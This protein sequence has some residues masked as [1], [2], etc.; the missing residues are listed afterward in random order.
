MISDAWLA[1]KN[2]REKVF[3]LGNFNTGYL[4]HFDVAVVKK[5]DTSSRLPTSGKQLAAGF[6]RD[7]DPLGPTDLRGY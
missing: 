7:P 2:T 1:E 3:Y 5:Y 4:G 6:T